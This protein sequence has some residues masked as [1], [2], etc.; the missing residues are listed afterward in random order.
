[1]I[2]LYG[3]ATCGSVKKARDWLKS[4]GLE[5]RFYELRRE[6]LSL[7]LLQE[8]AER[9]VDWQVLVNRKSATWKSFSPE[10]RL[11]ADTL[12]TALPLI[13]EYPTLIKRPV[14]DTGEA[15][16]IGFDADNYER[17]LL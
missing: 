11:L 7:A 5:Y 16:L 13:M 17:T 15:I 8:F 4:H 6:G 9:L 14:L 12:A 2:I 1:M 3:L 10:Q